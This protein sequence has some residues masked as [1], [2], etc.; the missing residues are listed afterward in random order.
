M[1]ATRIFFLMIISSALLLSACSRAPC[2]KYLTHPPY[3]TPKPLVTLK[4]PLN[5]VSRREYD[6]CLLQTHGVQVIRLGQTWKFI[7]PSDE[8]FDNDTSEINARYKPILNIAADFMQSYSKISVEVASYSN[9]A[10]QNIQTKFGTLEDDLTTRQANGVA[11]YFSK[12]H[13]DARLIYGTG[14]G[15]RD[16]VAWNG[17]DAGRYLNRRV[18]VSFK[19]YRDNTAWY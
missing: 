3:V 10:E 5:V 9:N 2:E 12:H 6:L 14:Q 4:K 7:F 19:Y 16:A 18:E 17:S 11:K 1:K 13:I 15:A 8:L